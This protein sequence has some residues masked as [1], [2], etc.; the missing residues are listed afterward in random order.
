MID[1]ELLR[2][3]REAFAKLHFWPPVCKKETNMQG[4]RPIK[5]TDPDRLLSE[6]M[7]QHFTKNHC[8]GVLTYAGLDCKAYENLDLVKF[9]C[10][11]C[12]QII[13]IAESN[14]I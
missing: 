6:A 4:N 2:Q 14:K 5:L 9:T 10:K 1:D 8:Y 7:D 3:L 13:I 11:K 12:K